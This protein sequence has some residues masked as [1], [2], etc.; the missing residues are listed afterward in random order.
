MKNI[1]MMALLC[2][3]GACGF[4]DDLY[5]PREKDHARFGVVQTG[6][7]FK[8]TPPQDAEKPKENTHENH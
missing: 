5:L 7:D 8:R 3:V 1:M 4:K 6:I 2:S